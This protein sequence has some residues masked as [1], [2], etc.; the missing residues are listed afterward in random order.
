M[1]GM[2]TVTFNGQQLPSWVWII[3]EPL[4]LAAPIAWNYAQRRVGQVPTRQNIGAGSLPYEVSIMATS[5]ADLYT[6]MEQ[7]IAILYTTEPKVLTRS[8]EPNRQYMA[9]WERSEAFN[10]IYETGEGVINFV[11]PSGLKE[12]AEQT[13][14]AFAT[15]QTLTIGGTYKTAP[16][17]TATFTAAATNYKIAHAN[18]Q[19]V[20][21]IRTF[22][23][24]DVL[25]I[26]FEKELVTLNGN[27][28]MPAL[29][30]ASKF[31]YLDPGANALTVTATGQTTKVSYKEKWL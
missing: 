3:K 5:E 31:F 23:A 30:L 25:V 6:K 13:G 11:V 28:I 14:A 18:G 12:R 8:S 22:A 21:V 2:K 24:S 4:E 27:A 10:R 20:N 7:L 26:D 29:D 1:P 16:K 9:L 17:V 15:T 19:Y